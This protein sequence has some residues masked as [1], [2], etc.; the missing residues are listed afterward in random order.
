MSEGTVIAHVTPALAKLG[1]PNREF[2]VDLGV[3]QA[4]GGGSY[5]VVL[6]ARQRRQAFPGGGRVGRLQPG[7]DVDEP[8]GDARR[9]HLIASTTRANVPLTTTVL[10]QAAG[11]RRQAAGGRR[12]AASRRR[13]PP[14]WSGSRGAGRR[15]GRREPRRARRSHLRRQITLLYATGADPDKVRAGIEAAFRDTG[16]I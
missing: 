3:R 15:P 8:L 4:A 7:E 1:L 9:E 6:P 16:R 12:H 11:G 14:S 5:H 10:R 13:R 2:A